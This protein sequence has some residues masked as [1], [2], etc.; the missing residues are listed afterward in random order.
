MIIKERNESLKDSYNIKNY[1]QKAI[2]H[3]LYTKYSNF[4]N[5]YQ[6]ICINN[7]LYLSYCHDVAKF[8]DYLIFDDNTEFLN[9]FCHKED[10]NSRMKYIF[11]FYSNYIRLYP[12]YLV[13]PEKKFI[14]KNIRK[15]QKII[16]E[17]N[18]KIIENKKNKNNNLV[19]ISSFKKNK[20]NDYNNLN[21][22]ICFDKS[23]INSS[24]NKFNLFN[25]ADYSINIKSY[26]MIKIYNSN[27]SHKSSNNENSS[28][29]GKI[30]L[31]NYLNTINNDNNI[32]NTQCSSILN[33]NNEEEES[34]KSKASITELINLLNSTDKQYT[35][36]NNDLIDKKAKEELNNKK[37]KFTKNCKNKIKFFR[38]GNSDFI[39]KQFKTH[40]IKLNFIKGETD[41]ASLK[42]EHIIKKKYLKN[43]EQ[44]THIKVIDK[45]QVFHRQAMSFLEDISKILKNKSQNKRDK[46]HI[47]KRK[48]NEKIKKMLMNAIN[49]QQ[50][51][52]YIILVQSINLII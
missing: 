49:L 22:N 9:E 42:K 47:L 44:K 35:S 21:K 31:K 16:D 5:S 3:F 29:L 23:S 38:L 34:K 48:N 52:I 10:L 30:N 43:Y 50:I 27:T 28:D 7:L 24:I 8:K 19:D 41:K 15:K 40:K 12:N 25:E 6:N 13:I 14:Y 17:K 32:T 37:L 1:P 11:N 20:W 33:I 39:K 36:N 2:N 4:E 18:A 45:N 26:S 51:K 46:I